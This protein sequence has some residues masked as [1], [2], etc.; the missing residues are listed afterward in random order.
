MQL[1][2]ILNINDTEERKIQLEEF[3]ANKPSD[4]DFFKSTID[5]V[6]TDHKQSLL[7]LFDFLE[8]KM[9]ESIQVNYYIIQNYLDLNRLDK[10]TQL[11]NKLR[12]R[13]AY[14][15]RLHFLKGILCEK[16]LNNNQAIEHFKF[17]IK[18]A[19]DD[20]QKFRPHNHL[21]EAYLKLDNYEE[22]KKHL[23]QLKLLRPKNVQVHI[24]NLKYLKATVNSDKVL[25]QLKR[26]LNLHP[27]NIFLRTEYLQ[28]IINKFEF[29]EAEE[30]LNETKKLGLTNYTIL[31]IEG[32]INRANE[33]FP[34]AIAA[35]KKATKEHPGKVIAYIKYIDLAFFLGDVKV[36]F[37]M[38]TTLKKKFP[39]KINVIKKEIELLFKV[40]KYQRAREFLEEAQFQ[41][42]TE[43]FHQ[44]ELSLE[45][46]E[47]HFTKAH[48]I[49][50]LL[51]S[52][53]EKA[54]QSKLMQK[55]NIC[56]LQYKFQDAISHYE[57]ALNC[58]NHHPNIWKKIASAHLSLGDIEACRKILKDE[59][60]FLQLNNIQSIVPLKSHIASVSNDIRIN[61]NVLQKIQAIKQDEEWETYQNILSAE[62]NYF[63]AALYFC[64]YLRKSG[65]INELEKSNSKN[66]SKL[67]PKNIVQ[68]FDLPSIP[69]QLEY[70]NSTWKLKNRNFTYHLF[71][72]KTALEFI[73]KHYSQT[74]V[75]AFLNCNN[76][77]SEADYFKL[78]FLN[79]FGGIYSAIN[80]ACRISLVT[81]IDEKYQFILCQEEMGNLGNNFMAFTANHPIVRSAFNQATKNLSGYSNEG[82]WFKTGSAVIT[83]SFAHQVIKE[84]KG[85]KNTEIKGKVLSQ[86]ELRKVIYQHLPIPH[87]ASYNQ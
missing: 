15:N 50:D 57:K 83:Q 60:T 9:P 22:A 21:F 4:F 38:I 48:E 72:K 51:P 2:E 32:D 69:N 23:E 58:K 16:K 45:L 19:K 46:A 49:V 27:K 37:D 55:G 29:K 62:P 71:N 7:K 82:P 81:L 24:K 54:L 20:K 1:H 77:S 34:E 44:L 30:F 31:V 6:K 5:Q 36:A 59:T 12:D 53:N 43:S 70:A 85:L 41:F 18:H 74:E 87:K 84:N 47:G 39:N 56:L 68:Y 66:S 3:F 14:N 80:N 40:G 64:V 26:S 17:A 11:I 42:K 86:Q 79:K 75:K 73:Q 8:R 10:A 78:A 67:I 61:M 28:Q 33:N 35:Y 25:A 63:G 76:A 13:P 52:E 65:V